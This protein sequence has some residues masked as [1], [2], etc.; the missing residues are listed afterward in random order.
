MDMFMEKFA[1][2]KPVVAL[3]IGVP[4]VA[5]IG[6][7]AYE[8]NKIHKAKKKNETEAAAHAQD[9]MSKAAAAVSISNSN[10]G[11]NPF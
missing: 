8:M 11:T 2:T 7:T 5:T 3:A 1:E 4:L 10:S 9:D 6:V